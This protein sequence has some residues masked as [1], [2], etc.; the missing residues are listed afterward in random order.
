MYD[1]K[2]IEAMNAEIAREL[3]SIKG[4][5]N[6]EP[7]R[8]EFKHL[9]LHCLLQRNPMGTWCGYVGIPKGHPWY[10]LGYDDIPATAHGGLTYSDAC[11]SH[12]CHPD[13]EELWWI[14]FDC[15]HAGDEIPL[16]QRYAKSL[17][18]PGATY[19]DMAFVK[20]EVEKLALQVSA[21]IV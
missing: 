14:G 1:R 7:N 16:M 19:K 6:T 2:A 4:P 8:V 12:I 18:F 13:G 17:K 3:E 11:H 9:N 15:A 10:G 5:W 20:S 21:K